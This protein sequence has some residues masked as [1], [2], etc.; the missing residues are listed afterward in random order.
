ML[1][2]LKLVVPY[3]GRHDALPS[4]SYFDISS[5]PN[6]AKGSQK[7]ITSQNVSSMKLLHIG[8]LISNA[9]QLVSLYFFRRRKYDIVK[10][11][12]T[13]IIAL[14]LY[15][16]LRDMSNKHEDLN[17]EGGLT[18][19]IWDVVFIT[20]IIHVATAFL[21]RGFWWLYLVI[22]LYGAFLLYSKLIVPF[23]FG[24]KDP[25]GG[26]LSAFTGKRA[27]QQQQQQPQATEEKLSKRQQKL[28]AR[29][30]KGDAR[31]QKREGRRAQ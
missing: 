7:K 19:L 20:W 27:P 30:D 24:G 16:V 11:V 29:A 23:V 26:L 3:G 8:F 22:P 28:Q 1:S 17:Q 6:M 2:V 25:I 13:E 9:S 12:L 5:Y 31:V 10:Y 18:A 21:W 15:L 4:C 14:G